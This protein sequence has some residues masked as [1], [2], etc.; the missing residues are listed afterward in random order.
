[1]ATAQVRVSLCQALGSVLQRVLIP[2]WHG[3]FF[4]GAHNIGNSQKGSQ[5]SLQTIDQPCVRTFAVRN[6]WKQVKINFEWVDLILCRFLKKAEFKLDLKERIG[7][8]RQIPAGGENRGDK[9]YWLFSE[10][11]TGLPKGSECESTGCGQ[12]AVY[13][14]EEILEV[15]S[16]WEEA[17]LGLRWD[18]I[19]T[20]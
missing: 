18:Q 5:K 1:M 12:A 6:I 10:E 4:P 15:T 8:S 16:G 14:R 20:D 2:R 13:L 11:G 17:G 3:R 19:W 9:V 7:P